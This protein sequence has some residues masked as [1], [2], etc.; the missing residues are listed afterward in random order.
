MQIDS[1]L[2]A[3]M[4]LLPLQLPGSLVLVSKRA[5]LG[6][7]GKLHLAA[8]ARDNVVQRCLGMDLPRV[9]CKRAVATPKRTMAT[10]MRTEAT[11]KRTVATPKRTVATPKCSVAMLKRTVAC[12]VTGQAQLQGT[13]NFTVCGRAS[14]YEG[15]FTKLSGL[16]LPAAPRPMHVRVEWEPCTQCIILTVL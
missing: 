3:C 6:K 15:Y 11:P 12:R 13:I 8:G 4:L 7:D 1:V 9:L 16:G 14:H 2:G 5:R 10:P